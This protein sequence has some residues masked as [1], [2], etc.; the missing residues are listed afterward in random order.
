VEHGQTRVGLETNQ[1]EK[2]KKNENEE[3]TK[4]VDLYKIK[5]NK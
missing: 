3:Y 2:K 1:I 5:V 4:L